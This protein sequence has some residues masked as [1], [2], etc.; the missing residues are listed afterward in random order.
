M[1]KLLTKGQIALLVIF[2]VLVIDQI[3][4]IWIKTHMYMHQRFQ[5]TD[6]FEIYFTQNNGMAFGMEVFSKLF[7]TTFRIAAVGFIGWYLYKIVKRN[8]KTGFIVCVALIWA[9]AMGNIID[10][11]FYGV[12]FTN[13]DPPQIAT[14]TAIGEGYSSWFHGKVV[15]MFYFPIIKS[16]W[17]TWFPF[18][19]GD[20]FTFFSPIFNFADAAISCGIIALLIFYSKYLNDTQTHLNLKRK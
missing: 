19:G 4:K 5:I 8:L 3:I 16:S 2:A 20:D 1:K 6:W 14:F 7:L 17:P 12:I 11:V 9:G 13:P 18:V 15:D 10:S